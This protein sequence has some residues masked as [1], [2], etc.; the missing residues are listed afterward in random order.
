MTF[1]KLLI[2]SLIVGA[3]IKATGVAIDYFLLW[4]VFYR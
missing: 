2:G 1:T 3:T 4:A